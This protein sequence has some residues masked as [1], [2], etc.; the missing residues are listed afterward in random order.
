[1]SILN[2]SPEL[3]LLVATQLRQVDLL[4]VSLVCKQLH[5]VTEPELYREYSN[6]RNHTRSFLPFIRKLIER[7]ELTKHVRLVDLHAWDMLDIFS[8][9]LNNEMTLADI[10]DMR[11][12]ELGPGDY[13][14]MTRAA[15]LAGVVS[16]IYPYE[17]SSRLIDIAESFYSGGGRR[18]EFNPCK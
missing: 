3:L 1:M 14:A 8:P 13:H 15:K 2:L 6:P 9:D 5:F 12:N 11:K 17:S 16:T 10:E 4:N 7:P 18:N